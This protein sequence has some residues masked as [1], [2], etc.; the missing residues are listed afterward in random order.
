MRT[1]IST[2]VLVTSIAAGPALAQQHPW[3][4]SGMYTGNLPSGN[5]SARA[6]GRISKG[7]VVDSVRWR[8]GKSN[9]DE[10][11]N[12][13]CHSSHAVFACPGSGQ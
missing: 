5:A 4:P 13:S 3:V 10:L 11:Y 6:Y 8:T 7:D 1:F 12:D 9:A 2:L